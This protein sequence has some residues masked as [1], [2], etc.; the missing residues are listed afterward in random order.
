VESQ[1][2]LAS[3]AVESCIEEEEEGES[4]L[5]ENEGERARRMNS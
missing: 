5:M 2:A 3:T 4:H 1:T